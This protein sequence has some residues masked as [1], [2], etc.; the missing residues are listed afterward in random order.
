MAKIKL[1][2]Q[3]QRRIKDKKDQYSE[4][5]TTDSLASNEHIGLVITR[6]SNK[7]TVEN[8]SGE[9]FKCS[10]RRNIDSLSAG[11]K[12]IWQQ[13]EQSNVILACSPRTS[14][15]G[16]PDHRGNIRAIAANVDQMI[17]VC[18]P[19]PQVSYLLIDSYLVAAS[20]LGIEPIIV[21]NK[22]DLEH[23]NELKDI[24]QPLGYK[25]IETKAHQKET[26]HVL[27]EAMQNKTSVFTGQSGVGKSS[28]INTLIPNVQPH[29]QSISSHSQLGKHTT[30]ASYLYHLPNGGDIIDS[31]GIR[32][33][34]LWNIEKQQIP[35]HFK[36]LSSIY[37]KCKYKNCSHLNE[38]FC[39]IDEAKKTHLICQERYAS[40]YALIK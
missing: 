38:P 9:I 35:R 29:T 6:S 22:T 32:E 11:D 28:L 1:S 20:F 5:I 13:G 14:V 16:R 24:Y 19:L 23:S 10:I 37:N 40:L 25:V 8:G 3:Q 26:L 33:F 30:S 2:K 18:A 15:L 31:P 34:S 39:A 12:V 4:L 7:A 21:F 17:I 27:V 36:E